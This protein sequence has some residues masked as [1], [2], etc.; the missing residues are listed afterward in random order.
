[1]NTNT[2]R[3]TL[4]RIIKSFPFLDKVGETNMS[5]RIFS[6]EKFLEWKVSITTGATVSPTVILTVSPTVIP[7]LVPPRD[8]T[9]NSTQSTKTHNTEIHNITI[10]KEC[11]DST[12]KQ[13]VIGGVEPLTI[14]TI[15]KSFFGFD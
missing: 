4:S 14:L 11:T 2:P 10:N 7:K 12:K 15:T 13:E 6:Y 9:H 1:M 5:H 8:Y 3:M